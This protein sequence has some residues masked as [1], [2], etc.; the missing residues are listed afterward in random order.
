MKISPA[1]SKLQKLYDVPWARKFLQ[2]RKI[3]SFDLL[4]GWTCPFA[5]ECKSKVYRTKSGL[6]LKDGSD[7]RFRCYMASI[8]VRTP[9]A[10]NLHRENTESLRKLKT[11]GMI[12]SGIGSMIPD[13]AGIVRIHSSGDFFNQR[14]FNA[15]LQLAKS[16]PDVLFYAYTKALTFW[17]NKKD[18][19]PPNLVLT[20]SY[21][22][23]LDRFIPQWGFRSATVVDRPYH[24][25]KIGLPIDYNEH[26]AANPARRNESFALLLHGP[27]PAGELAKLVASR[28]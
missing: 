16:R 13:D 21:G 25:R 17:Y 10:Y 1:N 15:W 20:A 23:M 12:A 28:R 14:Y 11:I 18:N 4:A 7:C 27:Q 26:I 5:R 2:G 9:N 24:A 22:G 6:R 19:I 3:Y 8:E